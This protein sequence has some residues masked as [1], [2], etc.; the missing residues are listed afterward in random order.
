MPTGY[1]IEAGATP[2]LADLAVV[3]TDNKD[4]TFTASNVA[5]GRYALR[6]RAI[7]GAGS[8]GPSNE[9][10]LE[11]GPPTWEPPVPPGPPT[12]TNRVRVGPLTHPIV[13]GTEHERGAGGVAE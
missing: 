13:D 6:V 11:V 2:G 8:S 4:A 1:V 9:V 7:N 12:G 10:W 5:P 3:S